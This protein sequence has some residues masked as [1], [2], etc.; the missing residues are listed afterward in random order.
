MKRFIKIFCLLCSLMMTFTSCNK[1]YDGFVFPETDKTSAIS[2]E[3]VHC[4]ST[5]AEMYGNSAIVAMGTITENGVLE[6]EYYD[7]KVYA[8]F[9]ITQVFKGKFNKGDIITVNETGDINENGEYGIDGVPLL[10]KGMN[11]LLFLSEPYNLSKGSMP[12][13]CYVM[14]AVAGKFFINS[15]GIVYPSQYF[16][17]VKTY[18]VS[19]I[20]QPITIDTFI[21]TL[22]E[23]G[24]NA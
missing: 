17:N 3:V 9:E 7:S 4:G 21:N 13:V 2:A 24:K 12:E 6:P 5:V 16:T 19:D 14:G 11:V 8:K 23:M 10:K 15:G 1:T 20:S 18:N 22:N